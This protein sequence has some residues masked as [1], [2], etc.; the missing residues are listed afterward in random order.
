VRGCRT[1]GDMFDLGSLTQRARSRRDTPTAQEME[2]R[3]RRSSGP[4]IPSPHIHTHTHTQALARG[5]VERILTGLMLDAC[6]CTQRGT[7]R[8]YPRPRRTSTRSAKSA[9]CAPC[10]TAT[11]G[12]PPAPWTAWSRRSPTS[13]PPVRLAPPQ[14]ESVCVC[15]REAGAVPTATEAD[16]PGPRT[17]AS[18]AAQVVPVPPDAVRWGQIRASLTTR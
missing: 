4:C 17:R 11:T 15:E 16:I 18:G 3:M 7:R 14:R 6:Q 5:P 1:I 8:S 13:T 10:R 12:S 2:A 9:C